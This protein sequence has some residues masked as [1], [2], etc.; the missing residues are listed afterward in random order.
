MISAMISAMIS[1]NTSAGGELNVKEVRAD[2]IACSVH[3]WLLGPYGDL[4]LWWSPPPPP[5]PATATTTMP[6]P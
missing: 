5:H 6:P 3:K 4:L 2:V 1:M